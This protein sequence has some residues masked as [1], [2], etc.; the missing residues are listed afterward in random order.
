[1]YKC[2]V[3]GREIFKK[4]KLQGHVL[5]YKHKR[6]LQKFGKFLDKNPRTHRDLNHYEI[7]GDIAVFD[8]YDVNCEKNG[9]FI[10]DAEDVQKVRYRKWYR[11]EKGYIVC[12]KVKKGGCPRRITY[13][14]LGIEMQENTVIDHINGNPLDNRKSNLRVCT[15]RE[16]NCNKTICSNNTSSICGVSWDKQHAKWRTE[17]RL[18]NIRY[19][20]G[21]WADF[22]DA[23]YVRY[24]A[25]DIL[26][27][28]YTNKEMHQKEKLVAQELPEKRRKELKEYVATKIKARQ[29]VMSNAMI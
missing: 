17:I 12:G 13:S 10:I 22:K 16:N 26:F 5:C 20:L 28:E 4:E 1:M 9:E 27:G 14:I 6:Q 23:V 15:K 19:K 2:E 8:T 24:K 3:C 29:S 7:H 21:R 11:N 25:E 18:D